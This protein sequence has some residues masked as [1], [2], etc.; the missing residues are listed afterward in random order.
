MIKT[1]KA[2]P[3]ASSMFNT[4]RSIG[5]TIETALAD[6][7]DNSISAGATNIDITYEFESSDSYLA[8]IDNG[9]GMSN[10]ELIDA[11]RPGSGHPDDER[12]LNDLGRFGLGLKTASLSQ[13]R[14]LSVLS[15]QDDQLNSWTWDLDYIHEKQEWLLMN[16]VPLHYKWEEQL[17]SNKSGTA[18][19]WT[20]LDRLH[21]DLDSEN[22]V[23]RKKF[24]SQMS[25][26]ADHLSM[27]F[28]RYIEGKVPSKKKLKIKLNG[29]KIDAWDP[30]MTDA[31]AVEPRPS[32]K[33]SESVIV[34]G[35]VLPHRS[36]IAPSEYRNAMKIHGSW[37]EHQ[38]F[39]VYR[40]NRILVSGNWLG[41]FKNERQYDLCRIKIDISSSLDKEWQIDIKKSSAIIP[42]I[43]QERLRTIAKEVRA[44]GVEVYRKKGKILK[45]KI[46]KTQ[47]EPMWNEV[48]KNDKHHFKINRN[49]SVIKSFL[50]G[51]NNNLR[52]LLKY[53]EESIPTSL[54][55]A[56]ENNNESIIGKP[57][58]DKASELLE[59]FKMIV[60]IKMNEGLTKNEAINNTLFIE[61][62]D[63]FPELAEMIEN[64]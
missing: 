10:D 19:I 55:A 14:R 27:V 52:D 40:N 46:T 61:P 8:I 51:D 54:I 32:V 42:A 39:Y 22:S 20:N 35:F 47:F 58:N 63:A 31:K 37:T 23:H 60:D 45:R 2:E 53:V 4:M 36:K 43:Y 3:N 57:F 17:E 62:F 15:K 24:F 59:G 44:K 49:N 16:K 56:T 21:Q 26:C 30:F 9:I 12:N 48:V 1:V 7:I 6:I 33:V 64:D 29:E 5:Y 11:L 34:K 41:L 13:C 50:K 18:V 28:H 38:G 25:K